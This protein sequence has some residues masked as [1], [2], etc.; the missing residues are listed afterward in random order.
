MPL[1][2]GKSRESIGKNISK[3]RSEKKPEAQAVAIALNTAREAGA[4]IPK[5]KTVRKPVSNNL[6]SYMKGK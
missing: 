1:I 6:T 2:K 5:P 3:L 4:R